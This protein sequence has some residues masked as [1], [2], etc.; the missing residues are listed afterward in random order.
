MAQEIKQERLLV[1]EGKDEQLFFG[2]LLKYINVPNIQIVDIGGKERF[3]GQLAAL[4]NTPGFNRVTTIGVIRDCDNNRQGAFD[5]VCNALRSANLP[6]PEHPIIFTA[7]SPRTSVWIMP[8]EPMGTDHMLEDLCLVA[9]A[10]DPATR[11]IEQFFDCLAAENIIHQPNQMAKA[12]LHVFLASRKVPDLR[13]GEAA[14]R[15]Y[16]PWD[17]LAFEPIKTFLY[18]LATV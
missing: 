10:D 9:V 18:Q 8:P 5:S 13:L 7:D 17:K 16:W 6:V 12:H 3:G 15:G 14:Q 4:K 2:A 11:C 1:V